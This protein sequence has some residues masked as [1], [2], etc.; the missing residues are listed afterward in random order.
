MDERELFARFSSWNSPFWNLWNEKKENL[1]RFPMCMSVY[2]YVR[3][4]NLTT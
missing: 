1:S 2:V 4:V 3:A